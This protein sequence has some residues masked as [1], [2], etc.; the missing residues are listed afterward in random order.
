MQDIQPY[1][2]KIIRPDIVQFNLLYQTTLIVSSR[3]SGPTLF[4]S[5]VEQLKE[6][7]KMTIKFF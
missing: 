6:Y 4:S 1:P 5:F 2:T 7:Q 3:I